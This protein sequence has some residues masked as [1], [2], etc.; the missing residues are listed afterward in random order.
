MAQFE[1]GQEIFLPKNIQA[2][3]MTCPDSYSVGTRASSAVDKV[4][5][6]ILCQ[7]SMSEAIFLLLHM[8]SWR[9]CR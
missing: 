2:S 7:G 5:T 4:A 3:T 1:H 6:S 9:A 8:P